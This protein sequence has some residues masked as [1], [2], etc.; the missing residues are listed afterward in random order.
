MKQSGINNS[1]RR[2]Q[3]R[4]NGPKS[5]IKDKVN[6]VW[7]IKRKQLLLVIIS[8]NSYYQ[9]LLTKIKTKFRFSVIL[10]AVL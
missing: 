9:L 10:I 3:R 6:G 5:F 1:G 8:K 2:A 4:I 7:N